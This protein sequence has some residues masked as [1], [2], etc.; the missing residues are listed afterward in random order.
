[1]KCIIYTRVSTDMQ[2]TA[3]QLSQLKEYAHKQNWQILDVKT[4][5]CSGSKSAE[6]RTFHDPLF[7]KTRLILMIPFFRARCVGDFGGINYFRLPTR[8]L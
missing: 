4:D 5:I 6:E 8:C 3:N 2:D 7:R 1:M